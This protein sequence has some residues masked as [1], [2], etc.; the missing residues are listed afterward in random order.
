MPSS[1]FDE[2]YLLGITPG[3]RLPRGT[4]R[5]VRNFGVGGALLATPARPGAAS[6]SP[7]E[8]AGINPE[9]ILSPTSLVA[10][11]QAATW[12]GTAMSPRG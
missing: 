10:G 9:S 1:R 11:R 5:L 6:N 2:D 3:S 12:Q 8:V 7:P 4:R